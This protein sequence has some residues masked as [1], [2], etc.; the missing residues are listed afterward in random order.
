MR[1]KEI[2]SCVRVS[3]HNISRLVHVVS[4]DDLVLNKNTTASDIIQV[5]KIVLMVFDHV[6]VVST[7]Q[8]VCQTKIH[9]TMGTNSL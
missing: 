4:A 7:E 1:G 3:Y 2:K 5:L 9:T 8:D 6:S